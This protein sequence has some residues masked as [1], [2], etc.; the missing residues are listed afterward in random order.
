MSADM[1]PRAASS[2]PPRLRRWINS[3]A[4]PAVLNCRILFHCARLAIQCARGRKRAR[5]AALQQVDICQGERTRAAGGNC[6][7]RADQQTLGF[8]GARARRELDS[9]KIISSTLNQAL[10]VDQEWRPSLPPVQN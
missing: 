9:L 6:G 8:I 3:G 1:L 5:M 2:G 4:Q 7:R 10:Q